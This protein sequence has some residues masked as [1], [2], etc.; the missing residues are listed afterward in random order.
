MLSA[1]GC[2]NLKPRLVIAYGARLIS[3]ERRRDKVITIPDKV[4]SFMRARGVDYQLVRHRKSESTHETANAAHVPDDHIAK[5]VVVKDAVGYA[6][7]VIP[8]DRCYVAIPV[9]WIRAFPLS[10]P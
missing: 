2:G 9:A 10:V 7:A 4:Q 8:G 3:K 1:G 6:V 5:A